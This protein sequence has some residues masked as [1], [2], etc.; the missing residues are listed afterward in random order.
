MGAIGA[1]INTNALGSLRTNVVLLCCGGAAL[2][3]DV[4][5]G[6]G[7]PTLVYSLKTPIGD[8]L[9][10]KL[11]CWEFQLALALVI[12]ACVPA[13]HLAQSSGVLGAA[14]LG[15]AALLLTTPAAQ[16]GYGRILLLL[17]AIQLACEWGDAHWER[18]A[19][20]RHRYSFVRLLSSRACM[21]ACTRCRLLAAT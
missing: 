21:H 10:G 19:F 6:R 13:L 3:A 7:L 1:V 17:S 9:A 20:F 2:F 18:W 8:L 14:A 4:A 16:G 5:R 15:P 12:A 11:D